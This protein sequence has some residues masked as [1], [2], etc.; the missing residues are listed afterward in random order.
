MCFLQGRPVAKAPTAVYGG[1]NRE[2]SRKRI[3]IAWEPLK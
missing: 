1:G 2:M 3:P